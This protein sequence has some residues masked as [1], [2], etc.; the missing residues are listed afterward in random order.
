M[1]FERRKMIDII[2]PRQREEVLL[3]KERKSSNY[4]QNKKKGKKIILCGIVLLAALLFVYSSFFAK[5][6]IYI[7]PV[8]HKF[9]SQ[10]EI[11]VDKKANQ[12]DLSKNIVPGFILE[13]SNSLTKTFSASGKSIDEKKA[14][15]IIRVY[16][17]YSTFSQAFRAQ[18][19]FMAASGEIFRTPTRVVIPGKKI[20]KGKEVPGYKDIRVIADQPGEEYNIGPTTF[21]IP[22]LVGTPLYT[23]FY[24]ESFE[25]MKGGYR[26]E[27]PQVTEEDIQKAQEE[28]L[29]TLRLEGKKVLQ[30]KAD[31]NGFVF[32]DQALFEQIQSTSSSAN[33]G[34]MVDNFDFSGK[35]SLTALV[36]RE[37]DIEKIIANKIEENER[38][39]LES[40]NYH[41]EVEKVD[42]KKGKMIVNLKFSVDLYPNINLKEIKSNVLDKNILDAKQMIIDD[43]RVYNVEIKIKPFWRK[44]LPSR[45][46]NIKVRI[47]FGLEG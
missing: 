34:E 13:E 3:M 19:R 36:F 43:E 23:K 5:A 9:G 14:E 44:K 12:I 17:N 18:T 15:G 28:V 35:M 37:K 26:K 6:E 30:K 33:I 4:F 25:P 1:A 20:E 7:K 8:M 16:N 39:Y 42:F 11:I 27:K 21:S 32:L 29:E 40:L 2:P 22:G 46:N 47:N 31:D 45:L 38:I 41:W 24:A 10:I